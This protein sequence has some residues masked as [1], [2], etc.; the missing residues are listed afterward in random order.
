MPTE[1]RKLSSRSRSQRTPRG[2]SSW[3]SIATCMIRPCAATC[4][5]ARRVIAAYRRLKPTNDASGLGRAALAWAKRRIGLALNAGG[6]STKSGIPN[7]GAT[8]RAASWADGVEQRT[9]ASNSPTLRNSSTSAWTPSTPQ[10]SASSPAAGPREQMAASWTPG[11]LIRVGMTTSAA[12]A[13]APTRP[14]RREVMSGGC[15]DPVRYG[16]RTWRTICCCTA[17]LRLA[18]SAPRLLARS[19]DVGALR[20]PGVRM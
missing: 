7:S 2:L 8:A 19:W 15:H 3:Q 9:A 16:R 5:S 10:A 18:S 17:R 11:V 4:S 13:P 6:L 20:S 1:S 12:C 14:M